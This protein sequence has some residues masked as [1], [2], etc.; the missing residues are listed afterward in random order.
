MD[1]DSAENTFIADRILQ[2]SKKE[3]LIFCGDLISRMREKFAKI[4]P[5]K[6]YIHV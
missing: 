2:I 5:F 3:D 6:V 1:E 4:S